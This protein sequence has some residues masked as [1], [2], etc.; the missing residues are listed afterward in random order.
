MLEWQIAE[1]WQEVPDEAPR[2][3]R[4]RWRWLLMPLLLALLAAAWFVWQAPLRYQ[5]LRADLQ[6]AADLELWAWRNR[7]PA[8]FESLLDPQTPPAWRQQHVQEFRLFPQRTQL[9][10]RGTP[11]VYVEGV[12]AQ[13]D[14]ALAMLRIRVPDFPTGPLDYTQAQPYRYVNGRW[15]RTGP[16]ERLWGPTRRLVTPHFIFEYPERDTPTVA[17]LA[18][19]IE[20]FYATLRADLDLP[21]ATHEVWTIILTLDPPFMPSPETKPSVMR[22]PSPS[23]AILP[24][25]M[26]PLR[27]LKLAVGRW[28]GDALVSQE[29]WTRPLS[30]V[31]VWNLPLAVTEW[32][33]VRWAAG[34]T[35]G[36]PDPNRRPQRWQTLRQ[37]YDVIQSTVSV[38]EYIDAAYGRSAV[39]G[40]IH[41]ARQGATTWERL[42]P[43]A[44]GVTQESFEPAWLRYVDAEVSRSQ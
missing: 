30:G 34:A 38:I 12:D 16:D 9:V 27:Y 37:T 2:P 5:R 26:T 13:G 32:D 3:R 43:E 21:T 33:T 10:R 4:P 42:L 31:I 40:V 28:L 14:V 36:P 18:A 17:A 7:D 39:A 15:A 24:Q 35:P 23:L 6:A 22:L 29:A 8:L 44:L 1:G 11:Q 25:G 20:A 41:A 19:E